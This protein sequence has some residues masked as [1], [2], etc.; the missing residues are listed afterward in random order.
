MRD[1]GRR[2]FVG[3][4]AMVVVPPRRCDRRRI[5]AYLATARM[6]ATTKT[7]NWALSCGVSPGL[8]R[9][10]PVSVDIDQLLCLPRAVDA[11]ERLFV[12]QAGQAVLVGG[13][14]A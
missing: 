11:G 6:T 8:S 4:E 12:Q 13:G 10:S 9:F 3:A 5:S 1:D 7:R 14:L 2:G